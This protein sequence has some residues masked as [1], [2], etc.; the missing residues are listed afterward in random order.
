MCAY[1]CMCVRTCMCVYECVRACVHVCV[2]VRVLDLCRISVHDLA[3]LIHKL[4]L[5]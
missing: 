2:F 4:F 3:S 1:V 5:P